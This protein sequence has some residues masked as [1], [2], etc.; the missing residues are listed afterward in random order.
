MKIIEKNLFTK[1]FLPCDK[2][3]IDFLILHN[4]AAQNIDEAINLLHF[5][6]VSSHYIIDINGDIYILVA[7]CDIAFHAGISYWNGIDGL[8][9]SS[10]G[11]EF[12][13]PDPDN[14]DFTEEQMQSGIKLCADIKKRYNIKN[15]NII[16]HLDIAYFN[17][18]GKRGYL[19]RKNDPSFR[20]DWQKFYDNNIGQKLDA[21]IF[22]LIEKLDDII[23]LK[24]KL[25]QYGYKINKIDDNLD[26][27]LRSV[28]DIIGYKYIQDHKN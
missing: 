23:L 19:G 6:E 20:F 28:I 3:Q 25:S 15:Q 17:E 27:Q 14:L 4:I 5:N 9:K 26:G 13:N 16:G 24:Q 8:N 10:I 21:D 7:E 12:F 18:E 22:N 1:N 2:R 11:I